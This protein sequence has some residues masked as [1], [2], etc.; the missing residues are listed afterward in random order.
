MKTCDHNEQ[1]DLRRL[2][3][4][5]LTTT[6]VARLTNPWLEQPAVGGA[7][8]DRTKKFFKQVISVFAKCLT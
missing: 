3:E 5:E 7:I 4:E 1:L 6:N 2:E 8:S